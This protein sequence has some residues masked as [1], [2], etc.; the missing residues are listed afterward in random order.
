MFKP[1]K[2]TSIAFSIIDYFIQLVRD[3][4]IQVGDKLPSERDMASSLQVSRSTVRTAIKILAFNKVVE[5]RKN[6]GIYLLSTPLQLADDVALRK[7]NIDIDDPM[8]F[9]QTLEIRLM[10]EPRIARLAAHYI[11][12]G[13]LKELDLIIKRMERLADEGSLSGYAIEDMNFHFTYPKAT[14]N[15][16]LQ[17]MVRQYCISNHHLII[18]GKKPEHQDKSLAQHKL[19]VEAFR[20]HDSDLAEQLMT[21]HCYYALY[22]NI[23]H[24]HNVDS[25]VRFNII[26]GQ[27]RSRT[28]ILKNSFAIPDLKKCLARKK[29]SRN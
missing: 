16:S 20:A 21:D 5:V 15:Y 3:G 27:Y 17:C 24:I 11:T 9:V 4:K 14:N 8:S 18:F 23:G 28:D 1:L 13:Q 6:S 19:I 2:K 29:I 7:E 10:V 12:D 25:R 26:S 22:R